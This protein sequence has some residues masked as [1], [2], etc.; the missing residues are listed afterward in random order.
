MINLR[1][2]EKIVKAFEI[3]K[4]LHGKGVFYITNFGVCLE[5]RK[6]GLILDL[7]FEALKTYKDTSKDSFRIE[8]EQKEHRLHYEF[9]VIGSTR[10]VFD[11]Y[12]IANKQFSQS[13]SE[14]EALKHRYSDQ[15]K[16][17]EHEKS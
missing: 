6:N 4:S 8:W 12:T 14:V 15:L 7:P 1:S 5:T 9:N 17:S 16:H 10:E 11:T 13:I 2:G 3:K